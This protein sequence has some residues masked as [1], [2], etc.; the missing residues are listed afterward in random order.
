MSDDTLQL[1]DD[2]QQL[3]V[4]FEDIVQAARGAIGDQSEDL[5][6]QVSE[7]LDTAREQLSALE[8]RIGHDF[9]A[10]ARVIDGYLRENTWAALALAASAAFV[11]GVLVTRRR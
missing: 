1:K 2:L 11:V 9:R 6:G 3:V 8:Q 4:E 7:Y 10:G 5:V